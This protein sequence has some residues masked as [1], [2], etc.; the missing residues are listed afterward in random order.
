MSYK[1]TRTPRMYDYNVINQSSKY[2]KVALDAI[3]EFA[4]PD[5][6]VIA[7][8]STLA[9]LITWSLENPIKQNERLVHQADL[10]SHHLAHDMKNSNIKK[11]STIISDW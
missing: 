1:V 7:P 4:P 11:S 5:N 8:T 9:K 3:S 2:G 10:I 6:P